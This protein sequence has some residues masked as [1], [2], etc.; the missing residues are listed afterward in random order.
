[1]P[2]CAPP[3]KFFSLQF[4][5]KCISTIYIYKVTNTRKIYQAF[6][7]QNQQTE[8]RR[9]YYW[10]PDKLMN[11]PIT[12]A[13]NVFITTPSSACFFYNVENSNHG[14]NIFCTYV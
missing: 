12:T 13:D 14:L 6:Y 2:H 11:E 5:G 4:I 3:N 10:V 9:K 8:T 1:M 7:K